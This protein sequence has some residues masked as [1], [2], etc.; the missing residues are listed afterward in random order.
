[1]SLAPARETECF[2]QRMGGEFMYGG[3]TQRSAVVGTRA[4]DADEVH[5]PLS[6]EL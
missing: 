3:G 5:L 4:H 1:M 6:S 2:R